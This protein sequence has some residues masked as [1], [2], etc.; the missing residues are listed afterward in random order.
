MKS[1]TSYVIIT[2]QKASWINYYGVSLS[3]WMTNKHRKRLRLFRTQANSQMNNR[4]VV[5]K[6]RPSLHT[7]W[8][9]LSPC[10]LPTS[11]KCT[12]A[13]TRTSQNSAYWQ[14]VFSHILWH[15]FLKIFLSGRNDHCFMIKILQ[16]CFLLCHYHL[17]YTWLKCGIY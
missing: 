7:M 1:S 13:K 3:S 5:F 11:F 9:C 14:G 17:W 2:Q 4:W 15:F 12:E 10:Q 8:A 6:W 16:K